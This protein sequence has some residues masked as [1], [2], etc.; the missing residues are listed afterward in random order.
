MAIRT[1]LDSPCIFRLKKT[2][3]YLAPKYKAI[4]DTI[5]KATDAR[6]NFAEYRARLKEAV[7]PCLPFLGVYLTDMTFIEDGNP[8][9]RTTPSGKQLINFDKHLKTTRSISEI[10][11]FQIPYRYN[12]ITEVQMFLARCLHQAEKEGDVLYERSLILEPREDDSDARSTIST[13][14]KGLMAPDM[15]AMNMGVSMRI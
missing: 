12:E 6:R 9:Y 2:W 10:Q 8:D 1:A 13:Q 14:S 15:L 4:Y 5:L 7:A 11:R 3:D